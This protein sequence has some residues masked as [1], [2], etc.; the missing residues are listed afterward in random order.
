M[1]C[2]KRSD[3]SPNEGTTNE[4]M[5]LATVGDLGVWGESMWEHLVQFSS[6]VSNAALITEPQICLPYTTYSSNI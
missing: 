6:T 5:T 1:L 4:H 3:N 2:E